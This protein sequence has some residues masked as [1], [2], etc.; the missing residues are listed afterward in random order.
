MTYER[1]S[2]RCIDRATRWKRLHREVDLH[3][4]TE[5]E[6]GGNAE[7]GSA[8]GRSHRMD[9]LD[10]SMNGSHHDELMAYLSERMHVQQTHCGW[11]LG[12]SGYWRQSWRMVEEEECKMS[13]DHGD[14]PTQRERG[15]KDKVADPICTPARDGTPSSL[16]AIAAEKSDIRHCAPP[17]QSPVRWKATPL[18]N[19]N[20]LRTK[21]RSQCHAAQ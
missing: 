6:L 3:R 2:W 15:N 7:S 4:A 10:T 18:S 17:L 13:R 19:Q 21:R 8:E 14:R 16:V 12:A 11:T 20:H 1:G 9:M 5:R